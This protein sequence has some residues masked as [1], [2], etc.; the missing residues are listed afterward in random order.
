MAV[1]APAKKASAS[2]AMSKKAPSESKGTPS[3]KKDW[4]QRGAGAVDQELSRQAT[5]REQMSK[6]KRFYI[7]KPKTSDGDS[8]VLIFLDDTV[9]DDIVTIREHSLNLDDVNYPVF[10]TCLHGAYDSCA[11]HDAGNKASFTAFLSAINTHEFTTK[12]GK[13]YRNVKELFP[14]KADQL[15]IFKR[16]L[17]K[18]GLKKLRG[19]VMDVFRGNGDKSFVSG[20]QFDV[21][22][23]ID[24]KNPAH[25][26]KYN[27]FDPETKKPLDFSPINYEKEL[28]PET[29]E[30]A[31]TFC[32]Q[33]KIGSGE[34]PESEDS[35]AY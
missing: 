19:V 4:F 21:I 3:A 11:Y 22:E 2:A 24:F 33:N 17:V 18:K 26:K 32:R 28:A 25:L 27:L 12:K 15:A 29:E 34:K 20:D 8:R 6:T 14:L 35:I 16:A 9:D 13:T 30:E 5:Q 7:K 10:K 1:K 31:R 23:V